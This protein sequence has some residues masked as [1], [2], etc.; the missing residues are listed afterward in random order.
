MLA[1]EHIPVVLLTQPD[2]SLC[3]QAK[4]VLD[5]IAEDYPLRVRTVDLGSEEGRALADHGGVL[6][7]PGVLVDGRSFSY[8]RLSE[9][10]LR[11]ELDRMSSCR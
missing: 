2:C 1:P 6:F 10:R 5:R 9:R 3:D 4:A 11:R 8:G 7:P